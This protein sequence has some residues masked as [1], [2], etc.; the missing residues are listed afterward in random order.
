MSSDPHAGTPMSASGPVAGGDA[1]KS[2]DAGSFRSLSATRT[3]HDRRFCQ[4]LP[5]Q[6]PCPL[7]VRFEQPESCGVAAASFRCSSVGG[8]SARPGQQGPT[9]IRSTPRAWRRSKPCRVY[10]RCCASLSRPPS[11]ATTTCSE[12]SFVSASEVPAA[13]WNGSL[14]GLPMPWTCDDFARAVH[15]YQ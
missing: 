8:G 1:G 7:N 11:S 4:R 9:S 12:S 2:S 15:I 13:H 10:R 5:G 14:S 6:K 3:L